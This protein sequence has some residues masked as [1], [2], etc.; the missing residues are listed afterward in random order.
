MKLAWTLIIVGAV[1]SFTP[2]M[3][4]PVNAPVNGLTLLGIL[5]MSLGAIRA[6]LSV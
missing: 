5:S 2:I 6:A 4:D 1:M 3:L